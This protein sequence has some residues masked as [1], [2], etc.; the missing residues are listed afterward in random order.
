[1]ARQGFACTTGIKRSYPDYTVYD[2]FIR[3]RI[4]KM[5]AKR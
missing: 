3:R 2:K 5:V 4:G 1:M